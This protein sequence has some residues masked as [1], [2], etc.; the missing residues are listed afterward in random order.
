MEK[1]QNYE[2]DV[3]DRV[4]REITG[5]LKKKKRENKKNSRVNYKWCWR[6]IIYHQWIHFF[7]SRRWLLFMAPD[8]IFNCWNYFRNRN[9]N[10]N[11]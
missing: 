3:E 6:N 1:E 8:S 9:N 5:E 10:R 4:R 7:C 2:K 11:I